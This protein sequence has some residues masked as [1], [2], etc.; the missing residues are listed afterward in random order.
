MV[1][2]IKKYSYIQAE[3]LGVKIK[4][5]HKADKKIDVFDYNDQYICSIGDKNYPDFPTYIAMYGLEFAK[6]R[7]RLYRIRHN[8]EKDNLGSPGYYAYYLLW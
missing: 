1:Y 7:R 3:K 8:K 5:S 6:E 2:Q 4:P